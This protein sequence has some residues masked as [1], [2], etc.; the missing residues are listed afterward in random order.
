MT[1]TETQKFATWAIWLMRA[2][3][4]FVATSFISA[5]KMTAMPSWSYGVM[6]VSMLPLLLLEFAKLKTTVNADGID[7]KFTPF[8]KKYF[9]WDDIETAEVIDYGFVGGWGIRLKTKYGTVYNTQGRKGL[10]LKLKNGNQVV[11][12]TQKRAEMERAVGAFLK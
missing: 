11:I 10:W 5:F 2:T 9:A 1:F 4:V 3:L 6:L 8:S 12:G 7:M